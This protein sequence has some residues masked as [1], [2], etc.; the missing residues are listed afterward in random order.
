MKGYRTILAGLAMAILPAGLTYLG[1]VDWTALVGPNGALAIA[2]AVTIVMRI[3]TTT[4]IGI[5]PKVAFAALLAAGAV[6]GGVPLAS[7]ADLPAKAPVITNAFAGGYPYDRS[8]FF[9]GIF[10]EGGGGSVNGSVPGVGSASLTTTSAG[11][12]GTLGY[13]WAS[14]G[15]PVAVS[16]EADFGWTNI[17][18]STQGFSFSGPAVF[19]QRFVVFSPLATL[20]AMLP[21]LPNLGAVPPFPALPAG[22]TASPMQLGLFA[23]VREAD[24]ST[25][26]PGLASNREWRISPEIGLMAMEQLSNNVAARAW[27]KTV[28]PDKGVCAGPVQ[29]A[30]AGLGQQVIVGVGFYY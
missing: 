23:G 7:A 22:V 21:N 30:C 14:K 20:M 6:L 19:E 12:G 9:F 16:V 15:S 4:P 29:G 11:V 27:V 13:A 18:G 24:I 8:G 17:N 1:G 3:I 2:G 25:N 10:T 26:F 5:P 28:F